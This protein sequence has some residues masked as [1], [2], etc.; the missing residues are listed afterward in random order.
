[1]GLLTKFKEHYRSITLVTYL[2][3]IIVSVIVSL[4]H[5]IAFWDI[6]NPMSWAIFLSIGIEV[7]VLSSIAASRISNAAW[8][9]FIIV[10]FIQ[11]VGNIFFSYVNVDVDGNLFKQWVELTDP[12]FNF[13]GLDTAGDIIVHKRIV[14]MSGAFVPIIAIVFFNFFIRAIRK[15]DTMAAPVS[16]SVQQ[17]EPVVAPEI[18]VSE[19]TK[20]AANNIKNMMFAPSV[21]SSL[22]PTQNSP[23]V[24]VNPVLENVDV[25]NEPIKVVTNPEKLQESDIAPVILEEPSDLIRQREETVNQ[26]S[27][28]GLLEN[29]KPM[30]EASPIVEVMQPDPVQETPIDVSQVTELEKK[31]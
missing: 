24:L 6:T 11:I 2:L 26:W 27:Q 1:M 14:A 7:G 15:G 29:L 19:Q 16:P 31:K 3:P 17:A 23:E 22:M 9:P 25:P 30:P 12:F 20:M 10:T 28:N 5:V 13:I 8:I 18:P 21:E 4:A